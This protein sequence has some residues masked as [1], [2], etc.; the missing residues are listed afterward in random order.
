MAKQCGLEADTKQGK[1]EVTV[2]NMTP[3]RPDYPR[4]VQFGLP[5]CC[6]SGN[7]KDHHLT[8]GTFPDPSR[9]RRSGG[10]RAPS[11]SGTR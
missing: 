2:T 6:W 3:C 4:G 9:R 1:D 5:W 11:G 10:D 7:L 8:D